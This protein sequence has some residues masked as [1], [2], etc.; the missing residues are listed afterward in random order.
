MALITLKLPDP[1]P[2]RVTR[3]AG[4]EALT[5]AGFELSSQAVAR[6]PVEWVPLNGKM[7]T[8]TRE[9]FA[10]AQRRIDAEHQRLLDRRC[11]ALGRR[12]SS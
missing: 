11:L 3:R 4:A 2:D 6:F 8:D 12:L 1:C 10:E 5:Q 9:L 7:T